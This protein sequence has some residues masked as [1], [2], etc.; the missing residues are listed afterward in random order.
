MSYIEVSNESKVT[1]RSCSY[2]YT[3]LAKTESK[4]LVAAS[5]ENLLCGWMKSACYIGQS[6][7]DC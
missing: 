2:A 7:I 3:S 1:S 5:D 6:G 4:W